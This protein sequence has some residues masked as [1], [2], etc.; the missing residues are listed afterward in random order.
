MINLFALGTRLEDVN[1]LEKYSS[2]T[3]EY[4]VRNDNRIN[5]IGYFNSAEKLKE[6]FKVNTES[7]VSSIIINTSGGTE[8]FINIIVSEC[9]SPVLILAD[10]K[11]NSFASSIEAYAYLKNRY[12]V[13]IGYAE[14]IDE[15]IKPVEI[16]CNVLTAIEKINNTRFGLIGDPSDWLLTSKAIIDFGKFETSLIKIKIDRLINE[17]EKISDDSTLKMITNWKSIYKNIFVDDESLVQSAKV[18]LALKNLANE[19]QLNLLTVRCFD[20]LAYNYTACMGISLCNDDGITS[21]CEGDIPATFTMMVAQLLSGRAV[22]MANPSSVNKQKNEIVFAHC[23]VPVTFLKNQNEAELTTHMESGKST[24]LRG[25]LKKSQ[26]TILRLGS[27][28]DKMIAVKGQIVE[29]DMKD[30]NL[31][32]TQAIIKIEGNVEEWIEN[33]LGNHQVICYGDVV[34]AITS[35]CEYT[36]IELVEI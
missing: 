17:V 22:W 24:A 30:D 26:V 36:G 18:Y 29:S 5:F 10:N 4:I 32:R 33:S 13:K 7:K 34:P 8:D 11:R 6:Y 12:P 27:S 25:E 23:T 15:K 31:C 14:S 20:L 1:L 9:R 35:F 28:F 3:V 19:F 16:F 21:G 2:A